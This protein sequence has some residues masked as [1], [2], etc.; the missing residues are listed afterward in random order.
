MDGP[1]TGV[2][3]SV[4]LVSLLTGK[5]VRPDVAMTGEVD[6]RGVVLPVGGVEDKTLGVLR[7][8]AS[9]P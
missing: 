6:L 9:A 3:M 8:G 7:A 5:R 1:S 4:A 2:A